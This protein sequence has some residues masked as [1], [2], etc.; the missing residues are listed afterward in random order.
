VGVV[1]VGD[2]LVAEALGAGSPGSFVEL[3]AAVREAPAAASTIATSVL[4]R[5]AV[6]RSVEKLIVSS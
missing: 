3:H 5:T 4:E 6:P 2:V 1:A